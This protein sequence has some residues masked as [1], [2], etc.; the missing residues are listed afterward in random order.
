MIYDIKVFDKDGKLKDVINGHN[1]YQKVYGENDAPNATVK[2]HFK[3]RYCNITVEQTR[4]SKVTCG[5]RLCRNKHANS[6]RKRKDP[7][8]MTCRICSKVTEVRHSR[9]ITCSKE[10]A[11][12]N[13]RR[14]SAAGA[15]KRYASKGTWNPNRITLKRDRPRKYKTP[16]ELA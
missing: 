6:Y 3:C 2:G 11:K 1:S 8:P 15:A 5:S 7:R 16:K 12:E 10:C 9:Q 14:I 4:T 13:N